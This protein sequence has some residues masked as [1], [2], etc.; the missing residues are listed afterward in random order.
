MSAA[1]EIADLKVIIAD[2]T[3]RLTEIERHLFA[4][5]YEKFL[6]DRIRKEKE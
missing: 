3:S 5:R 1:K 6:K 4:V 2:L